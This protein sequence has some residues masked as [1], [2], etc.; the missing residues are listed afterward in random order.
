MLAATVT[1]SRNGKALVPMINVQGSK[2]K[3][4]SKKELGVWIPREE[5]MQVLALSEE[6]DRDNLDPWLNELGNTETPLDNED[7]LRVGEAELDARA[8][9]VLMLRA[10][11]EVSKDKGDCLPVTALN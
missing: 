9:V 5:G 4:L 2:A 3:L 11:R 8:I 1:T 6:L 7:E 10:Y